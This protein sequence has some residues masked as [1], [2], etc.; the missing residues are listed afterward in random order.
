[1]TGIATAFDR[2][3]QVLTHLG[4]YELAAVFGGIVRQKASSPTRMAYLSTN[5]PIVNARSSSRE[6]KLGAERYAAAIA[7]GA[8]MSYDEALEVTTSALDSSISA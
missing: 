2:G 1:M 3:I 7:R 4:H 6:E 5:Y 8:S